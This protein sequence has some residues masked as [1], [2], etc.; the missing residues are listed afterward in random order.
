MGDASL[1][2]AVEEIKLWYGRKSPKNPV[3]SSVCLKIDRPSWLALAQNLRQPRRFGRRELL[4]LRGCA[5][6]TGSIAAC[7]HEDAACSHEQHRRRS[8][9]QQRVMPRK[10]RLQQHELA[11]TRDQKI[12]HLLIAL[13]R[14]QSFTHKDTQI[15]RE[16]RIGI[17]DR[18]ILADHPAHLLRARTPTCS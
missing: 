10:S 6:E 1:P 4:A 16:W 11:V 8:K 5:R 12:D 14:V 17:V 18:L 13:A 2:R 3:I 9:L 7:E 15:A